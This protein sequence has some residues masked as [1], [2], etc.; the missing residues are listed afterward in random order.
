MCDI[1]NGNN[2]TLN[3]GPF[4]NQLF[5]VVGP[6]TAVVDTSLGSINIFIYG[7]AMPQYT[8]SSYHI[9]FDDTIPGTYFG[10]GPT[11]VTVDMS[12]TANTYYIIHNQDTS[13][14]MT[15]SEFGSVGGRIK[16][17]LTGNAGLFFNGAPQQPPI[18]LSGNFDVLRTQ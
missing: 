11:G 6:A 9:H 7:F 12:D 1:S 3:W 14:T 16:G 17:S 8:I 5:N 18:T 2:F 15:L 10:V 4:S 13:S